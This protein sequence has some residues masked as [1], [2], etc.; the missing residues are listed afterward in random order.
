MQ[1]QQVTVSTIASSRAKPVQCVG[2][3]LHQKASIG[4]KIRFSGKPDCSA[5][6]NTLVN[7]KD[8]THI[9]MCNLSAIV[10]ELQGALITRDKLTD[11]EWLNSANLPADLLNPHQLGAFDTFIAKFSTHEIEAAIAEN[12]ALELT[13]THVKY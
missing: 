12:D 1:T 13:V 9:V 5:R 2:V 7:T 4:W 10:S 3:S 8:H 11:S 6:V